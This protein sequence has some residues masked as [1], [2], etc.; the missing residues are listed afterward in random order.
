VIASDRRQAE[1]TQ[2]FEAYLRRRATPWVVRRGRELAAEHRE[3][4][5]QIREQYGV[6]PEIVVAI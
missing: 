4:L 6:P 2:T 5:A 1:R 3:L